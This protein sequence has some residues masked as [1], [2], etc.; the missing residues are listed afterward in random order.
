MTQRAL[1]DAVGARQPHIAGIESGRRAVSRDLLDRLL[2]AV[3]Y[4]PS[5]ALAAQ[6]D[7]LIA[8]GRRHGIRRLRVFG[9]IAR[10]ADHHSSDVDLLVDVDPASDPFSV[11]LFVA[12]ATEL[13][14][15][16]VDVVV[17]DPET[18]PH[19]LRTA[20]PL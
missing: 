14:G 6:R 19:I 16:P 13:L 2:A 8:L 12:A 5:L 20:V 3:D 17:D 1:A 9:S 15:F 4:R 7:E 10:G 18:P 11:A